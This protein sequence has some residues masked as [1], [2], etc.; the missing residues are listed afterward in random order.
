MAKK[1]DVDCIIDSH[2]VIVFK[3][4]LYQM[5]W[6]NNKFKC[7]SL[8]LCTKCSVCVYMRARAHTYIYIYI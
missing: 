7:P 3:Y 6:E 5:Q 4:F 1:F 2:P 8:H